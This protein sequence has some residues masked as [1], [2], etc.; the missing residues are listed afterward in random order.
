MQCESQVERLMAD[1]AEEQRKAEEARERRK[2]QEEFDD[3]RKRA[4]QKL[5][6]CEPELKEV[7]VR[8][9]EIEVSLGELA[10]QPAQE[11]QAE[12][13]AQAKRASMQDER[14]KLE[15]RE[16]APANDIRQLQ[17]TLKNEFVFRPSKQVPVARVGGGCF[18]PTASE[19]SIA[20]VPAMALPT[21]GKLLSHDGKRYLAIV[22]WK[23]LDAGEQEAK[24]LNA[25][26]TT[27][28][29]TE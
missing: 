17:S 6:E 1:F 2:Q 25:Q 21:V 20:Q 29:G 16:E 27:M 13:D 11:G 9:K 26:L 14:R 12:K 10:K 22:D 15:K 24:R 19:K 8:L 3:T 5:A 23:D 7:Q 4:E 18:I 28:G